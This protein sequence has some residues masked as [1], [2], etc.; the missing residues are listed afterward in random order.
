MKKRNIDTQN[1]K[2]NRIKTKVCL[3]AQQTSDSAEN[4]RV[5]V[6]HPK[7][8]SLLPWSK[9]TE[10]EQIQN[11]RHGST[12]RNFGQ[13]LR[14]YQGTSMGQWVRESELNGRYGD[15]GSNMPLSAVSFV[16]W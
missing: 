6:T 15:R 7:Y 9:N 11:Y 13:M 2:D 3:F 16:D 14:S 8:I 5:T 12:E 4:N 1:L 10:A